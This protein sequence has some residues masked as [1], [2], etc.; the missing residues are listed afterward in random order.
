[1]SIKSNTRFLKVYFPGLFTLMI[2]IGLTIAASITVQYQEVSIAKYEFTKRAT[3]TA[4][5][6]LELFSGS[7]NATSYLAAFIDTTE[8][9]NRKSFSNYA[10]EII[11]THHV[12]QALEWIP[13]VEEKNLADFETINKRET[14]GFAVTEKTNA[15]QIVPVSKRDV[16][17]PVQFIAPLAS[18]RPAV[19]YDL[20]SNKTRNVMLLQAAKYNKLTASA[21]V[22][23]VQEKGNS[24]SVLVTVPVF[25]HDNLSVSSAEKSKV[26]RG[27]AL[28]VYR[29][30]G[31]IEQSLLKGTYIPSSFSFI[32]NSSPAPERLLYKIENNEIPKSNWFTY[33]KDINIAGRDYSIHIRE[34]PQVFLAQFRIS[35]LILMAGLLITLLSSIYVLTMRKRNVALYESNLNLKKVMEEIKTLQ[36]I[37][38]I[39]S[40]CHSIRDDEGAWSQ[41]ELYISR[42][43]DAKFSHGVCPKCMKSAR[44]DAGLNSDSV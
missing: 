31:I 20:A 10:N 25:N 5:T 35:N 27:Y 29:I 37:I 23:L 16:Y 21:G 19:G 24:A 7:I 22:R 12:I 26:L 30:S 39:C 42:H 15:G 9:I 6:V 40:Y 38:P 13:R 36:G 3:D 1:M 2:G 14:Q 32:D 4:Q 8:I 18:N 17:F 43:S 44:L 41:V 11:K 34:K 33:S 28:G